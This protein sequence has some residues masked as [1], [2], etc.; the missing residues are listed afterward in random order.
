M[1]EPSD[2]LLLPLDSPPI[3][4]PCGSPSG[5]FKNRRGPSWLHDAQRHRVSRWA[6][7]RSS[8]AI[9]TKSESQP[10]I[11]L[12]DSWEGKGGYAGSS[13]SAFPL[14][15]CVAQA[16]PFPLNPCHRQPLSSCVWCSQLESKP[17]EGRGFGQLCPQLHVQ[18][19]RPEQR[20]VPREST[21]LVDCG[22]SLPHSRLL[23]P[24]L[25]TRWQQRKAN[26][27]VKTGSKGSRTLPWIWAPCARKRSSLCSPSWP[28]SP[29]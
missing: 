18:H 24:R 7:P 22:R 11:L 14:V 4:S 13:Q 27:N 25:T 5:P 16:V 20:L 8:E 10:P 26:P 29:S 3:P 21:P 6:R 2:G 28:V 19:Q 15:S 9:F 1:Q 12:P 23:F 17:R